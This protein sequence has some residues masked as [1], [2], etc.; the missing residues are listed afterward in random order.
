MKG[1]D[2]YENLK[3]G[4]FL[5][6]ARL[7]EKVAK[8]STEK[9]FYDFVNS[10]GVELPVFKLSAEEMKSLKG[11]WIP[12]LLTVIGVLWEVV[13]STTTLHAPTRKVP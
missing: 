6:V 11:G 1:N 2:L 4:K 7:C 13:S 8:N 3:S 5:E 10:K 12:V 9:E